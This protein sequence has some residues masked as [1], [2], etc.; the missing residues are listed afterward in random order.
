[1]SRELKHVSVLFLILICRDLRVIVHSVPIC[2][3]GHAG[4]QPV[5]L[6]DLFDR[7]IQH[8]ARMHD[9]SS[10]L[11]SE[12]EQYSLPSKNHVGRINRKCHTSDILTPNGKENAQSLARE[13]L[14]EVILR[15]LM[16][17]RDPLSQFQQSMEDHQD[18]DGFSGDK[19]RAMSEMAHELKEGVEK[20]AEKMQLL[21]MI[22]NS[23][24]GLSSAE[25][26]PPSSA[27]GETRS[28][29][30]YDLLHCFRRDSSKVQSYLRIL[31]CR[32]IPE[33]EC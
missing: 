21:G 4:C 20:V 12:F 28:M 7:V 23:L 11:H 9:L 10:D 32:I 26:L 14:T 5:S 25:A 33:H 16:A 3:D 6:A 13:E 2:T 19:A 30:D 8:S 22:G 27:S 18:I 24:G 29:S 15:L 1:M 31:K 17:W